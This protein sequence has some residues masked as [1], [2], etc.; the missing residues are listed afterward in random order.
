MQKRV[1]G[2]GG[3]RKQVNAEALVMEKELKEAGWQPLAKHPC[4][5]VWRDPNGRLW[6][7]VGYAWLV[8]QEEKLK[9]TGDKL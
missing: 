7:G 1:R 6:P 3:T 9:Q 4:S 8:M 5:P 2:L